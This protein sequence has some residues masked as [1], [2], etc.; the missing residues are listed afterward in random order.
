MLR[1]KMK[2]EKGK[3]KKI[4][5]RVLEGEKVVKKIKK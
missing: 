5:K 1:D 2:V 4:K 3:Q